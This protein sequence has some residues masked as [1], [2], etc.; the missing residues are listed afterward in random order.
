MGTALRCFSQR[1]PD[2]S[3]VAAGRLAGKQRVA[4]MLDRWREE[5]VAATTGA[6]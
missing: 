3:L 4:L 2:P 5:V 1:L 6:T